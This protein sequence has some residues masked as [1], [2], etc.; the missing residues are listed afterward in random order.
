M[1]CIGAREVEEA[2]KE[3]SLWKFGKRKS[4]GFAGWVWEVFSVLRPTSVGIEDLKNVMK[5]SWMHQDVPAMCK[6]TRMVFMKKLGKTGQVVGH[7]RRLCILSIIRKAVEKLA[8]KVL[9]RHWK[10][11]G[12]QGGYQKGLG[13]AG[14][15]M[16][17]LGSV[18]SVRKRGWKRIYFAFLDFS[19]FF[20]SVKF[21]RFREMIKSSVGCKKI[22][23]KISS[24]VANLGSGSTRLD[25]EGVV[26]GGEWIC[27][28]QRIPR[29]S[30][31]GP[32]LSTFVLDGGLSKRLSR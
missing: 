21:S 5:L 3:Q 17:L 14:R 24:M 31:L 27:L 29:G 25:M 2:L 11:S 1:R 32:M 15:W 28:D 30:C 13:A 9:A 7:W 26:D 19:Q 16:I 8:S 12:C 20:G 18:P 23:A 22:A 4:G 6:D 10:V